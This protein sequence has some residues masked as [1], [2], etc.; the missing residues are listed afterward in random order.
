MFNKKVLALISV[1]IFTL[2][3]TACGGNTPEKGKQSSDAGS[4]AIT[5]KLGHVGP[6]SPD[7]PWEKYAKE[8]AKQV[9]EK[10]GGKV[11]VNTYPASQLGADRE[12][13]E[14]LQQGTMEM[15]LISTIAMGNFVPDLQVWDLP[16]IFPDDPTKVDQILEGPIGKQ[17][18]KS[19]EPKG[20]I[21]LG[22]WENDWRNMSNSK[23]PIQ[24]VSDMKGLKMR[25]VENKPS[26]DWFKRVGTIPT[27]MAFSEVYTALQ[28]KTVDGQD[29]GTVLT[30]GTRFHEVQPYYT[31][32]HHMYC[33]LALVVSAKKWAEL[34]D[35]VKKTIEQLVVEVGRQQRN[36]NRQ[37]AKEYL[38][39]IEA[40]GV[41]AV[42][43]LSDEALKG[44]RDSTKGTYEALSPSLNK[45]VLE[46]MLKAR[47]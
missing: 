33:P 23:L 5:L 45:E 6:A 38:D 10:T 30:Y 22:Y 8:F 31:V 47:G 11:V 43:K 16:Y 29:N 36:F 1:L 44:F 32:T 37:I 15:G 40:S 18:A 39:K 9:N 28:Q 24:T 19:A 4:K 14:A 35:D 21:I 13:T 26:L 20:L 2:T 25:I 17:L 46:A 3:L 34:P 41:K 7:H 42:R 12:M 27:P